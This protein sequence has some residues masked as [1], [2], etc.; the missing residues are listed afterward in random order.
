[1]YKHP[2][3]VAS[4]IPWGLPVFIAY[5]NET[6]ILALPAIFIMFL[7]GAYHATANTFLEKI[8]TAFA[9]L[10]ILLGPILLFQTGNAVAWTISIFCSVGALFIWRKAKKHDSQGDAVRYRKWHM[11]WHLITACIASVIYIFYFAAQS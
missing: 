4:N 9:L 11:V 1:M 10:Y 5:Y 8:D 7:S 6:M 3:L 2:H